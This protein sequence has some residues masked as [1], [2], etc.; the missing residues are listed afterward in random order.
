[1]DLPLKKAILRNGI[2]TGGDVMA[3]RESLRMMPK[4]IVRYQVG[5]KE[6]EMHHQS[7]VYQK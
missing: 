1:M 2:I 5:K 6:D 7:P 3:L 4:I